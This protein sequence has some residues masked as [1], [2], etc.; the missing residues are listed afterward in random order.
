MQSFGN[1]TFSLAFWQETGTHKYLA[2][3]YINTECHFIA[4]VGTQKKTAMSIQLTW[5]SF[6]FK[7]ITTAYVL[8]STSLQF[9]IYCT[10]LKEKNVRSV[11]QIWLVSTAE[12]QKI[13]PSLKNFQKYNKQCPSTPLAKKEKGKCKALP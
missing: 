12:F 5:N 9:E 10:L 13:Q 8:K 6:S 7:G 2:F 4:Q 11:N 3:S 1:L